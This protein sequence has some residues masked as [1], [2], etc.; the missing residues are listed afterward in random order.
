MYFYFS[1]TLNISG[2]IKIILFFFF[3]L[4]YGYQVNQPS[5]SYFFSKPKWQIYPY[6]QHDIPPN[7]NYQTQQYQPQS[8]GYQQYRHTMLQPS[9][10]PNRQYIPQRGYTTVQIQPSKAY[11]IKETMSEYNT[12]NEPDHQVSQNEQNGSPIIVLRIPGP[13]KYAAHLQALLQQYL[14]VRAAQYIKLLQEQEHRNQY[15]FH[16]PRHIN[17]NDQQYVYG[18]S[19]SVEH[20]SQY[21][22]ESKIAYNNNMDHSNSQNYNE[23]ELGNNHPHYM[24]QQQTYESEGESPGYI[25][26]Q[27][28]PH[29]TASSAHLSSKENYPSP[30]HTQVFY[31]SSHQTIGYHTKESLPKHQNYHPEV[32]HSP[33]TYQHQ[34][35]EYVN[36][37]DNDDQEFDQTFVSGSNNYVSITQKTP[38]SAT[39]P[40]YNYHA[41]PTTA[42]T[43]LQ[44]T[45][46]QVSLFSHNSEDQYKK[47]TFLANRLRE[48]SEVAK[49]IETK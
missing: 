41:H 49:T 9:Q 29:E 33:L 5:Q 1:A 20:A 32:N 4:S 28:E 47:F 46:Q 25:Y 8:Y 21:K 16:N 40:P 12:Y 34:Q 7:P 38:S 43:T 13:P 31:P 35:F 2:N 36:H 6:S 11:E 42:A 18:D 24:K 3:I 30:D 19:Q 37:Q 15:T 23:Q 10:L 26:V 48:K 22:H 39:T 27:S 17:N 14:E 45:K 44:N